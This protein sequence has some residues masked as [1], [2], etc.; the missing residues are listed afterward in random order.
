MEIVI[1]VLIGI[2]LALGVALFIVMSRTKRV[3]SPPQSHSSLVEMRSV[4]EL[5]VFRVVTKEI[6]AASEHMFGELG[7]NYLSWLVSG[8]KM[9][10]IFEFGIDFKYDLRSK[11]FIIEESGADAATFRMPRC[12]YETHIRD[13]SFYD[14]QSAKLLPGLLP[15]V[16]SRLFAGGFREEDKNRL[17][18]AARSQADALARAMVDRMRPEVQVSAEQTLRALARGFGTRQIAVDFS[19]SA[20][21]PAG[22][23]EMPALENLPVQPK[24]LT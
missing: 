14:E 6:V 7:K 8:K 5:V 9:A 15:E 11:D 22:K 23:V 21:V 18:E 16:I 3:V 4:G 24:A 20:L 12:Q 17:K 13:V 10:M 1:G 2:A 19:A